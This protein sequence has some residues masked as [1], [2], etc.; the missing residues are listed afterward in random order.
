M[1]MQMEIEAV[2]RQSRRNARRVQHM[3]TQRYPL[4]FRFRVIPVSLLFF[5]A[6]SL[7]CRINVHEI[8]TVAIGRAHF[9]CFPPCCSLPFSCR[10]RLTL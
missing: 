4:N 8:Q 10:W 1:L 9:F 2:K 5:A 3:L 6:F 7:I